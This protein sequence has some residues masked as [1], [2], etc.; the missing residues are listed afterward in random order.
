MSF[1]TMTMPR[2][3]FGKLKGWALRRV[4]VT[5]ATG[6]LG[7]ALAARLLDLGSEVVALVHDWQMASPLMLYTR[8]P[9]LTLIQ[10]DIQDQALQE[11]ALR[12]YEITDFFHL[13]AQP[14]VG[15]A[16]AN[17]PATFG[18]NVAGT[19]AALEAARRAATLQ[20]FVLA[21]SD[22]A[23][24]PS[25]QLPY[26]EDMALGAEHPYDASKVCAE[27]LAR[28]YARTYALPIGITRC[29]NLYGGGDLNFSRIVPGTF[30]A[31]LAGERPIIR[32]DGTYRRQYLY[33]DDAVEGY[34][35]LSEA[36]RQGHYRGEAFNFGGDDVVTVLELVRSISGVMR[37][38]HLRPDIQN[39]A[40]AEIH[41]QYLTSDKALKL[42]GWKARTRLPAGLRKTYQWYKIYFDS[43]YS[44]KR[45]SRRV[46]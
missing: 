14:L 27:V 40:K 17:P 3:K 42:L 4:F 15:V 46:R 34:L 35:Y 2:G 19:W 6:L 12:Q 1:G 10:G 26:T 20:S 45:G 28:S 25:S 22:K 31:L 32:S 38:T 9:R 21:S 13:A 7:S 36:L 39:T 18:V 29:A 43:R 5:G 8:L 33:V 37:A 11:R 23:Y 24:G 44:E 16:Y 41:D 30:K